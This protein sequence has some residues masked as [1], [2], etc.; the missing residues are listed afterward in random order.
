MS[1]LFESQSVALRGSAGTIQLPTPDS[2][3]RSRDGLQSESTTCRHCGSPLLDSRAVESGFCCNGCSYV[4]RLVHEQGL[5]GYYN[6]K[7]PITSPADPAVFHIRDTAWIEELQQQAEAR[8]SHS[9]HETHSSHPPELIVSVQGI[10]CAGCVWLIE[11]VFRQQPGARSIVVS[12]HQGTMRLRWAPGEF[13]AAAFARKLQSLGYL[14]GPAD[15]SGAEP[16]SRALVRR[17]GLCAAFAMN[18]MLYALPAYFGMEADFEYAQLFGVLTALFGTLSFLVGGTYFLGRAVGTLRESAMH[19][20]LPIAIGIVGA[21]VGSVFGWLAGIEALVYFD[22]LSAFILL[23]LIG[24]WAQVAAVERNRRRL[25]NQQPTPQRLKHADGTESA[26]EKLQTD[27]AFQLASAQ[28]LPVESRLDSPQGLFSLASINGESEP[29]L[30][31]GGQ[32]V[33]AGAVNAGRDPILLTALQGWSDS[34]LARLLETRV[35]EGGRHRLLENIV[36]GYLA[37]IL[38]IAAISGAWWWFTTGDVVLTWSVVTAVLVVSC[39][40]AIGLAFPLTDE[41]ATVGLR[42]RGVFVLDGDLWSRLGRV[43]TLVFDKTGTLTLETPVLLNP[44]ALASLNPA[45]RAA[46]HTLVR[47]NPHP[48]SQCLLENLLGATAA[49]SAFCCPSE[50]PDQSDGG[51][52]EACPTADPAEL[53]VAV[54]ETIGHGVELGPWSLGRPGWRTPHQTTCKLIDDKPTRLPT[55]VCKP[56]DDKPSGPSGTILARNGEVIAGFRFADSARPDARVEL[57]ALARRGFNSFILSGDRSEK[58]AAL[59]DELGLP[60][61]HAIGGM[62]PDGKAAWIEASARDALMLGDGANDSLAFESALCRGTPVIHR[63]LLE[64]KSDFYYL[65]RGIGGVRALLETDADRR[66][67]Q[68]AILAFSILYNAAAVGL[69]VAGMMNPLIA[70]VL[71]PINSLLTLAI[72]GIGMRRAIRR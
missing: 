60:A 18:V 36:K 61:S 34:L 44:E 59:A 43:R 9:S 28:T 8:F 45:A 64:G 5:A 63:G 7:D 13:S 31:R 52:L 69:A 27:Q 72:V 40:C 19:I 53:S 67:T 20:D 33:P 37:G 21:F 41:M 50:Q 1:A 22:F 54:H 66:H 70:A 15:A 3:R 51:R 6:V 16:E 58:V 48:I 26:P 38:G 32:R 23:M 62:S 42:R 68:F 55:E 30:F 49:S 14:T 35:R 56:I 65:G 47:D 12:P 57:A 11:R 71:M 29:R 25:L 2:S 24:R 39:P 4:H 10:S 17:I 46:L